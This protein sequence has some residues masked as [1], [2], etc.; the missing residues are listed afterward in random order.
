MTRGSRDQAS[1]SVVDGTPLPAVARTACDVHFEEAAGVEG[2]DA[3]VVL[4]CTT[5]ELLPKQIAPITERKK[6]AYFLFGPRKTIA[7]SSDL[8]VLACRRRVGHGRALAQ[9]D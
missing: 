1:V 4:D 9:G 8:C 7:K 3:A 2:H 6:T 5:S